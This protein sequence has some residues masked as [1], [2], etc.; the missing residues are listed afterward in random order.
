MHDFYISN[1]G[2]YFDVEKS[3]FQNLCFVILLLKFARAAIHR[4]AQ[5]GKRI[6]S[7]TR[8][9]P[10]RCSTV[11]G[12]HLYTIEQKEKIFKMINYNIRNINLNNDI[13]NSNSFL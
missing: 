7:T 3:K 4:R 2:V 6:V 10:K 9:R 12:W 13:M 5:T 11:T 8:A 1:S